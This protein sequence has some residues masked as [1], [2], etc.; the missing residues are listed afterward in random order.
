MDKMVSILRRISS[1]E[2]EAEERDLLKVSVPWGPLKLIYFKCFC[3][4][5]KRIPYL[6]SQ[7][8][9]ISHRNVNISKCIEGRLEIDENKNKDISG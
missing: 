4:V 3:S 1:E 5:C 7:T 9:Q 2:E 8:Q 6:V